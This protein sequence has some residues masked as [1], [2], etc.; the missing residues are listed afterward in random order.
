MSGRVYEEYKG[1]PC[2]AREIDP[3]DWTWTYIYQNKDASKNLSRMET[4][5]KNLASLNERLEKNKAIIDENLAKFLKLIKVEDAT[6]LDFYSN[7]WDTI[8]GTKTARNRYI[9]ATE[10]TNEINSKIKLIN[11]E[12]KDIEESGFVEF[13]EV[14]TKDMVYAYDMQ[15]YVRLHPEKFNNKK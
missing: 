12:L 14:K 5:N 8:K 10:A 3:T 11:D 6:D 2:V 1:M 7:Q 4:L 15:N 13:V 9:K